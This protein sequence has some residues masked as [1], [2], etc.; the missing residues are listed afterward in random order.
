MMNRNDLPW[1]TALLG[2]DAE[3]EGFGRLVAEFDLSSEE[4]ETAIVRWYENKERG[5]SVSIGRGK[6]EAIQFYSA[7]NPNFDGFKDQLPLGL[8][9]EMT[10]D[11]VRERF[12][13]PDRVSPA[14]H[15]RPGLEHSGIDR[16]HARDC[17][18]VITY[19]STSGRIEV[20]GFE[21]MAKSA[22]FVK[23][24]VASSVDGTQVG[25]KKSTRRGP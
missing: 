25:A 9:Y 22:F 7:E 13:D 8:D 24:A 2:G 16:Y 19:S 15:I 11:E 1:Y 17:T 5:V 20:M 18:V 23:S 10:R 4:E 3:G 14:I 6:V 21:S 12:G